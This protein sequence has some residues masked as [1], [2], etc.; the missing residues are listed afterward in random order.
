MDGTNLAK[1]TKWFQQPGAQHQQQQHHQSSVG[2]VCLTGVFEL[3]GRKGCQCGEGSCAS[4]RCT[5]ARRT[6]AFVT[7]NKSQD[8]ETDRQTDRRIENDRWTDTRTAID[9]N[10]LRQWEFII[11]ATHH[12]L[13]PNLVGQEKQA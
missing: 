7:R 3:D 9:R 13:L 4:G 1:T 11:A 6:R 12:H 5:E 2:T 8:V 10:L